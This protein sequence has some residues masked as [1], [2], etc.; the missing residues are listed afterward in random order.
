[1]IA[2]RISA[3]ESQSGITG[4]E[5]WPHFALIPLVHSPISPR[6]K[7]LVFLQPVRVLRSFKSSHSVSDSIR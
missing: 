4:L 3:S 5:S 7:K 6:I 1:M 2:S